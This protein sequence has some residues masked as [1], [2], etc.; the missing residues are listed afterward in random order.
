MIYQTPDSKKVLFLSRKNAT[1]SGLYT[2]DGNEV[3]VWTRV[4]TDSFES[5]TDSEDAPVNAVASKA[6]LT[7][8][9]TNPDNAD[10]LTVNEREYTFV[11]ALTA[12]PVIDEILIGDDT[13]ATL[14]NIKKALNH[15]AGEGIN[16]ST[17]TVVN[18]DL[19][20]GAVAQNAIV[21]SAL[22]K[23]VVG[24]DIEISVGS[25]HLSLGEGVTTL[26]DGVDGTPGNKGG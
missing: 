12:D 20:S 2:N 19:S 15:E 14:L 1:D 11:T 26:E 7:S 8:D 23:G 22:I 10:T 25:D 6:T 17:G 24:D 4:D 3:S 9:T 18:A 21:L 5:V 13:D 16:Y